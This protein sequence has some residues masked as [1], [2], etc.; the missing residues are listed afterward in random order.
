MP[1][2]LQFENVTWSTANGDATR[3]PT[4]NFT[5]AD[6]ELLGVVYP[7]NEECPPIA[8]L[9][10]GL[11]L[12]ATGRIG[13]EGQD[14]T[15]RRPLEAA[16]ARGRMR[17][18][19]A[20]QAWV[21][22]LDIDENV[23]LAQ[24]QHTRR[25]PDEIRTEAEALAQQLGLP[26]LPG[27]RPAW[28]PRHEKNIAQWVRALLGTPSLLVVEQPWPDFTSATG[29]TLLTEIKKKRAAGMAVLWLTTNENELNNDALE[30]SQWGRLQ[31]G[32]W[33]PQL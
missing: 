10:A 11:Q 24:R 19:F 27:T 8:D 32:K 7:A 20:G 15:T 29:Q 14:W 12:S 25:P 26:R 9:A 6:G 33:M 28:T 3:S 2:L 31:D 5:L 22:N 17:R 21:S 1:T 23:T 16:A 4:M 30:T 18:I 13:F